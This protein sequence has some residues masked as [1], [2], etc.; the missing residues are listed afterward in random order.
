MLGLL[1]IGPKA[2]ELIVE[3]GMALALE[4]TMEEIVHTMH[5]HPTL[6]EALGEAAHAT[7]HGK[8]LHI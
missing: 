1:I 6:S 4:S 2:T 7:A 3:G 5:A 8:A